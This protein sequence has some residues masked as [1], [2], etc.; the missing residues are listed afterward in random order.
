MAFGPGSRF[1]SEEEDMQWCKTEK[2][3]EH[4]WINTASN[5]SLSKCQIFISRPWPIL[6]VV[7]G[8]HATHHG[9]FLPLLLVH[10]G[11]ISD[12]SAAHVW[13]LTL[14]N[15]SRAGLFACNFWPN[16]TMG[17][18][19]IMHGVQTPNPFF[20]LLRYWQVTTDDASA[21]LVC[22]SREILKASQVYSESGSLFSFHETVQRM[23][24]Y[25]LRTISKTSPKQIIRKW[26]KQLGMPQA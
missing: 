7:R 11:R 12:V 4:T 24:S 22:L 17:Y 10:I 21:S 19:L 14:V 16:A 9:A 26:N 1:N 6:S 15:S 13:G 8:H 3:R 2:H 20:N 5:P 23:D 18:G 25:F